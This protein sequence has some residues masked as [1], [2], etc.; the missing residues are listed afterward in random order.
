MLSMGRPRPPPAFAPS[1]ST[2][3]HVWTTGA[4]IASTA[5]RSQTSNSFQSNA[6]RGLDLGDGVVGGHVIG[7]GLELLVGAQIQVG[8]RDLGPQPGEPLCVSPPETT[9]CTGN[10]S[11]LAVQLAHRQPPIRFTMC[12]T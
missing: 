6:T 11:H 4:T 5:S 3:P 9:C 10:D 12:Y 8:D 2:R 7:L 1:P